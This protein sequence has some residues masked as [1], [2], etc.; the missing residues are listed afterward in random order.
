MN[1]VP[2]C[3]KIILIKSSV[4]HH[5]ILGC[6][7]KICSAAACYKPHNWPVTVDSL[8]DGKL[9]I[10]DGR[11]ADVRQWSVGRKLL[12]QLIDQL[13]QQLMSVLC[14]QSRYIEQRK[15]NECGVEHRAWLRLPTQTKVVVFSLRPSAGNVGSWRP[16]T[17]AVGMLLNASQDRKNS[18]YFSDLAKQWRNQVN[19]RIRL[20]AGQND[21]RWNSES[22]VRVYN[23][24][25]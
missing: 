12:I 10:V 14:T 16:L 9:E 5:W 7:G 19:K 22:N 8:L 20:G 1:K 23:W 4:Y 15:N 17:A 13:T 11:T 18:L 24:H 25:C 21:K 6:R 2:R 3:K